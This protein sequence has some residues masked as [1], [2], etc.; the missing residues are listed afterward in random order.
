VR[1][2]GD[3]PGLARRALLCR[4][5]HAVEDDRRADRDVSGHPDLHAPGPRQQRSHLHERDPPR[6]HLGDDGRLAGSRHEDAGV[7][8]LQR[9][10]HRTGGAD[11]ALG[12]RIGRRRARRARLAGNRRGGSRGRLGREGKLSPRPAADRSGPGARFRASHQG[13]R[14]GDCLRH[15]ARRLQV[16]AQARRRHPGDE[17]DRGD[18]PQD[19]QHAPGHARLVLGAAGAAGHH[20]RVR[21]RDA[22]DLRRAGR[23]DR[24]RHQGTACA[25]STSTP[26]AAW[27]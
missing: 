15:L 7:L 22:A 24:S 20:Q 6:L 2:A 21:R 5:H 8:R 1:C 14:A 25:R 27:R 19:P 13:R 23:R 9:D 12:R 26:T 10:H 17:R 18:P 3:H 16:L 11:G 4:R